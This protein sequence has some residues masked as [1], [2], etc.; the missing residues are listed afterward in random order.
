[1]YVTKQ[2]TLDEARAL[3]ATDPEHYPTPTLTPTGKAALAKWDNF[4]ACE[5][6]K[7]DAAYL[8]DQALEAACHLLHVRLAVV[9]RYATYTK[10]GLTENLNLDP[11]WFTWSVEI[12]DQ[13]TPKEAAPI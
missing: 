2:L 4:V 13:P 3:A 7:F 5:G 8:E 6:A 1:M 10:S 12:E 9:A 11:N